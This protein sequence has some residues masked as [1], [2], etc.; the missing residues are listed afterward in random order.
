MPIRRIVIERDAMAQVAGYVKEAGYGEVT[1][2]ADGRTYQA[3][4]EKLREML[5]AAQVKVSISVIRENAMGEVAADEEAIVQV[6][7]DTP[8]SSK[9]IVAVWRPSIH[10]SNLAL[11]EVS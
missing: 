3:A 7:L 1:L 4:G 6:M 9:V 8:L 11:I 10:S 5:E 2:V